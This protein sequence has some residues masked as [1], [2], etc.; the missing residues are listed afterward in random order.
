MIQNFINHIALVVDA[1]GSMSPLAKKTV[2]V[3]DKEIAYLKSRSI[4]LNQETRVSVYL[5]QSTVECLVFDMDVMRMSSLRQYYNVNGAT[6]LIDGTMKAIHDMER[7]P[8][9]YGDHAFLVYVLTDGEEN[10][11][12]SFRPDHLKQT[13]GRLPE[14]WTIAVMV[15]DQRG[16]HE[17][18]KFGFSAGNIGIWD[19]SER[20]VESVGQNFRA[21]MD[22]FMANRAKGVRGTRSFFSTDMA[23]V[24]I[25]TVKQNL[26]EMS[27]RSYEIYPVSV[28]SEIR[29]FV[30]SATGKPY[31]KGNAYYELIKGE[32][33][34]SYKQIVV[35]N[36]KSGKCFGGAN[37]R[38][39]LGL[40]DYDVRVSPGDHGDWFIYVQSTSVNRK[41]LPNSK[42]LVI[43]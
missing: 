17:A 8:T 10:A 24:D 14:N 22:T 20:G 29:P 27:N 31:A 34:Q 37:A 28:T 42:V 39:L 19:T 30:E 43:K 4:E 33:I 40:P 41:L 38:R 15:P 18:K 6:A 13:I 36:K 16:T 25:N 2:E 26:E 12:R 11:S 3:F 35:Q 32:T 7:L 1:S 9:M 5:F 23:G 21:S